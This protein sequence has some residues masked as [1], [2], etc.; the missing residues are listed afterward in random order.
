METKAVL[1]YIL[2]NFTF[3]ACEKTEIPLVLGTKSFGLI[4]NNGI[5]LEFKPRV[6]A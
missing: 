6:K 4:P 2:L 5:W 3:E 1:Y